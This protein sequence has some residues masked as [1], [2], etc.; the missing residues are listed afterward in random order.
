M[1]QPDDVFDPEPEAPEPPA[2]GAC[3]GSGCDNCVLDVYQ[4]QLSDYR[5][6]HWQWTQR[7]AASSEAERNAPAAR[8]ASW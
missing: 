8:Q 3:C 2:D 5:L 7:Q 6:K 4:A 1:S